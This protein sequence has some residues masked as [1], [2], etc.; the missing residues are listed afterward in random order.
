MKNK[1]IFNM[2]LISLMT[3]IMAIFAPISIPIPLSPIPLSLSILIIYLCSYILEPLNAFICM[4][5]YLILA[6]LGLPVLANHNAGIS[7]LLG[8]SG[9][10]LFS[11]L[12]IA[13]ICSS[14]FHKFPNNKLLH[15]LGMLLSISIC[16]FLG[17]L[18][19]YIQNTNIS[20]IK[21]LSL[22]ATPFIL[23]EIL[24]IIIAIILGPNIKKRIDKL[25]IQ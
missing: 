18:W 14:T 4:F 5:L 25:S 11:Y 6:C 16:L 19:L 23:P 3:T 10:Y 24:K 2:I 22:G 17:S 21:A 7:R 1:K 20:F 12:I 13:F 8:P 15:I 9:G